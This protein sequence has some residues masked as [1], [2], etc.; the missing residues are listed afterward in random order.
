MVQRWTQAAGLQLP[1]QKT[2]VVDMQQPGGFD[3]LGYHFERDRRWPRQKSRAK[4]T[5]AVRAKTRRN[6]GH[7]LAVIIADV[8]RTLRGWF[9][10]FKHSQRPFKTEDAWVRTRLRAILRR[11]RGKGH[12]PDWRD[13]RRWPNAFFTAQG[14]FSLT[15][16]H[17]RLRQSCA[18]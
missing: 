8:N 17:A 5:D 7:R 15:Q 10:Y 3:F 16:A 14:L 2:C 12:H 4:L 6:H 18:R 9:D 11:R 13:H 1:P